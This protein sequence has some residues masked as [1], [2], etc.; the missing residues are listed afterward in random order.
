MIRENEMCLEN[1]WLDLQYE[2]ESGRKK[3]YEF[4]YEK[5]NIQH[6]TV[7]KENG[8]ATFKWKNH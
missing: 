4:I 2:N 1:T 5:S 7:E 6:R 3:T 8:S